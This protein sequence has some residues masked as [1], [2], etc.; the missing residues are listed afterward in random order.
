[1]IATTYRSKLASVATLGRTGAY[2]G[3]PLWIDLNMDDFASKCCIDTITMLCEVR[4]MKARSGGHRRFL[5][6]ARHGQHQFSSL[7]VRWLLHTNYQTLRF[8]GYQSLPSP[9]TGTIGVKRDGVLM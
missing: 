3:V 4:M 2:D 6:V 7:R 5:Y 9:L 1:M 8:E